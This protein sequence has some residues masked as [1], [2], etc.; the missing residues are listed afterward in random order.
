VPKKFHPFI[1]PGIRKIYLN[2]D[3]SAPSVAS[4]EDRVKMLEQRI[5]GLETDKKLL[6]DKAESNIIRANMLAMKERDARERAEEAENDA[7]HLRHKYNKLKKFLQ[8]QN[9]YG[10]DF[11][12]SRSVT[13]R[14]LVYL[15]R[16]RL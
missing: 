6:M 14:V 11:V 4:L 7:K 13:D 12:A 3:P 8:E 9:T 5:R 15:K 16:I 10:I 2:V 1:I